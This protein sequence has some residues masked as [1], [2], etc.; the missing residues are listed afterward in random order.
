MKIEKRQIVASFPE[1]G[2]IFTYAN[3]PYA[4]QNGKPYMVAH[5]A[6]VVIHPLEIL[7]LTLAR[8]MLDKVI[9]AD[10]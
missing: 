7:A 3:D 9:K 5:R 2:Q 10:D 1:N 4:Y 6:E 8:T